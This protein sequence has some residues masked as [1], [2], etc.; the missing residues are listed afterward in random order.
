[1][2]PDGWAGPTHPPA[3]APARDR[4]QGR[5]CRTSRHACIDW[6][7]RRRSRHRGDR[8]PAVR[9]GGCDPRSDRGVLGAACRRGRI[10]D[11]ADHLGMPRHAR[12]PRPG[13]EF[14]TADRRPASRSTSMMGRSSG[15]RRGDRILTARHVPRGESPSSRRP[16]H[17]LTCTRI[18]SKACASSRRSGIHRSTSTCGGHL[19]RSRSLEERISLRSSRRRSSRSTCATSRRD[20]RS[21]RRLRNRG[22]VGSAVVSA[23]LVK[24]P[25]PAVGQSDQR[26]LN[27]P[28][29]TSRTMSPGWVRTSPSILS[30]SGSRAWRS[31]GGPTCCRTTQYT[32]AERMTAWVGTFEHGRAATT[33]SERRTPRRVVRSRPMHTDDQLEAMLR[34]PADARRGVD[35]RGVGHKARRSYWRS[36]PSSGARASGRSSG[37]LT[38]VGDVQIGSRAAGNGRRAR[39]SPSQRCSRACWASRRRP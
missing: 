11:A 36:P 5:A 20:P 24:H 7:G 26:R 35:R 14:A 17:S 3:T 16:A 39:R 23:E 30:P 25:G 19:R 13:E 28:W 31:R 21:T 33:L 37:G 4:L 27:E 22:L 6:L 8:L 18:T 2:G 29:R 34:C 12:F 32:Q 1:M 9:A 38:D 10:V 15:P